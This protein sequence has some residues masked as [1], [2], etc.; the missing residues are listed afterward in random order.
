MAACGTGS[1]HSAASAT[2]T[3]PAAST[4]TAAQVAAKLAP[5]GCHAS[6]G[7]T[8]GD[9]GTK[10]QAELDCTIGGED[11]TIDQYANTGQVSQIASQAKAGCQ[12]AKQ[13]GM[14]GL[15]WVADANVTIAADTAAAV[16]RIQHALGGDAK[17]MS[18]HC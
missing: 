10:P 14:T 4:V 7:D 16:Q 12:V 9:T 8:S 15:Y 11:V 5:L 17:L 3:V 1:D 2:P 13:A 18:V 6:P